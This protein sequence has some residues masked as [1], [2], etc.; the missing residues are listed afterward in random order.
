MS[1]SRPVV[2]IPACVKP[3]GAHPFHVVGDKYIRAV[4]EGADCLPFLIPAL[5]GWHDVDAVLDRVD[6]LLVTGSLSNVEPLHYGGE[7]SEAGTLHDPDRDATTL[8]LIR[9]AVER[10]LPL[11]AICRGLQELNVVCGGTLH[12]HVERV[13]GRADHRADESKPVEL[14]Y[15]PAHPV[16]LAEGGALAALFGR[17]ETTVNTIHAQG[18][19]RLG[20][21]LRVEATAPDGQIEAV[22]I[23]AAPYFGLATQW[24]PEWRFRE[25]P[26][27]TALFQAFGQAV[28]RYA[29]DRAGRRA[30][31]E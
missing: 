28:R 17:A 26:D 30:A 13:P 5:G 29:A 2:G 22:R 21:G 9:R 11:L 4:S 31:A 10:G 19:D 7:A 20:A 23:E 14:Q 12:Q 6:G 16:A 1:A 24:H 3:L 18:V 25:N 27:S 8:P 15:G